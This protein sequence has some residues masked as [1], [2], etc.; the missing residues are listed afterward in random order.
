[1]NIT[2]SKFL[3]SFKKVFITI[4]H[5]SLISPTRVKLSSGSL[6]KSFSLSTSHTPGWIWRTHPLLIGLWGRRPNHRSVLRELDCLQLIPKLRQ[7]LQ[8]APFVAL[9]KGRDTKTEWS[10]HTLTVSIS[11]SLQTK[12][13]GKI[14]H[15]LPLQLHYFMRDFNIVEYVIPEFLWATI[16]YLIIPLLAKWHRF[17]ITL[18]AVTRL[19]HLN[20]YVLCSDTGYLLKTGA[21]VFLWM[22]VS[23]CWNVFASLVS[24]CLWNPSRWITSSSAEA[25]KDTAFLFFLLFF[26]SILLL[27]P[28]LDY[29]NQTFQW[30]GCFWLTRARTSSDSTTLTLLKKLTREILRNETRSVQKNCCF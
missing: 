8:M 20:A 24:I 5:K 12:Q 4:K 30:W 2:F 25:V 23:Y 1:M 13:A 7:R 19:C 27:S 22:A 11:L 18:T 29:L 16:S 17:L 10:V 14:T 21:V 15:L 3:L 9:E 6:S 28:A 26:Y